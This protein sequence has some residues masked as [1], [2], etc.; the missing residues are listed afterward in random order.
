MT[1]DLETAARAALEALKAIRD[2]RAPD[3]DAPWTHEVAA[4]QYSRMLDWD[5]ADARKAIAALEAALAAPGIKPPLYIVD[6]DGSVRLADD[7]A[8]IRRA[9]LEEA[10]A[11][12][13]WLAEKTPLGHED[14]QRGASTYNWLQT[15]AAVIR[16]LADKEPTDE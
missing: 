8:A 4:G 14:K 15:H 1:T 11:Y 16:A 2:R 5:R 12:L 9:A 6:F 10:A 3:T 13:E 7:P